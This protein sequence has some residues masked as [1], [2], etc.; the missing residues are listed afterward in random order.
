M[1]G[2]YRNY[3]DLENMRGV[4]TELIDRNDGKN[5]EQSTIEKMVLKNI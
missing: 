5:D 4:F 3:E 2:K 1:T